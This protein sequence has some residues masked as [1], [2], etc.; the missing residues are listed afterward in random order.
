MNLIQFVG[1]LLPKV[2]KSKIN[3]DLRVTMTELE[4]TAI[5]TYKNASEY[6]RSNKPSS[7]LSEELTL[8]FY[9]SFDRQGS[10]KAGNM[11][12]EIE[13]RLG[14]VRENA[15][16][17]KDLVDRDMETISV[18]TGLTAK[19]ALLVRA[20]SSISYIS[21]YSLDLLTVVYT[22]EAVK[23]NAEVAEY[24]TMSPAIQKRTVANIGRFAALLS[25]YGIPNKDFARILT[26]VPDVFLKNAI[27][28]D[29]SDIYSDAELDPFKSNY[30]PG[31]TYSPIYQIRMVV[32]EWQAGR[33]KANKDKKKMLELR[34]LHL[35]LLSEKK[36]DPKLE[37]EIQ[38]IQGRID[39]T[40]R[41]LR[42]VE[43]GLGEEE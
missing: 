39:S 26:G 21:R 27:G 10:A 35:K 41:Y 29:V 42:D 24:L 37:Q 8:A 7:S 17:L 43:D 11:I 4:Q 15:A 1:A 32:A 38:Y 22:A 18:S 20:A 19:K 14:Y 2:E 6:C 31:F 25:D 23:A 33:Y 16:Y 30:L 5:P 13:R 9:K 34:L 28:K 36:N 12:S 40:E 3:E